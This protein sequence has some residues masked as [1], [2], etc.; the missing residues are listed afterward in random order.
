MVT[1]SN[2]TLSTVQNPDIWFIIVCD[3]VMLHIFTVEMLQPAKCW[4]IFG[5]FLFLWNNYFNPITT[6]CHTGQLQ[7][8][9]YLHVVTSTQFYVSFINRK[10]SFALHLPGGCPLFTYSHYKSMSFRS[11]N[12]FR[13]RKWLKY[14]SMNIDS[15]MI[16]ASLNGSYLSTNFTVWPHSVE[17]KEAEPASVKVLKETATPSRLRGCG[18]DIM[19]SRDLI[20]KGCLRQR[21][22]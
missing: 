2:V 18:D 8:Q 4:P 5:I 1:S 21:A 17:R 12:S 13:C 6:C 11:V 3:T 22:N 14:C 19:E 9:V 20:R 7:R 15:G 10:A 16:T